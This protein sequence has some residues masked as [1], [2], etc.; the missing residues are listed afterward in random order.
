[1]ATVCTTPLCKSGRAAVAKARWTWQYLKDNYPGFNAGSFNPAIQSLEASL[2]SVD[3]W[4]ADFIPFNPVCCTIEDL[5]AQA[6]I[7]T[8]QMLGSVGAVNI[9]PPPAQT[10]WVT[11]AVVA[12][13]VLLLVTYSPQIKKAMR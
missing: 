5:G 13:A 6:D 3:S 9:P 2:A 8:N 7:L 10:D 11:L 12:G 1:M 4:Y